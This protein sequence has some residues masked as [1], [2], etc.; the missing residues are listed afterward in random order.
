MEK[1]IKTIEID[2]TGRSLGRVAAEVAMH[3]MGKTSA[4]FQRN[5]FSGFPVKVVNASKIRISNKKLAEI[6][7]ARY[8]GYRGGLR[9]IKGTE[10][11]EKEGMKELVRLAVYQMLPGNK[12]RKEMMKNL[13]IED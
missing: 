12:I 4:K 6:F 1:Q 3:L 9:I 5:I 11:A 7:H 13:K 10:T 2:A 8:S